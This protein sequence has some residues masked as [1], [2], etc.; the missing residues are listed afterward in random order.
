MLVG[1]VALA[2]AAAAAAIPVALV[3]W[4]NAVLV[5]GW[6]PNTTHGVMGVSGECLGAI[7]ATFEF[8]RCSSSWDFANPNL[9]PTYV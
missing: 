5:V 4:Q 7:W 9:L 3:R 6:P 2:A 8:W 1:R